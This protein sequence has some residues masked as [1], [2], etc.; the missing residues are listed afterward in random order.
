MNV[1][2]ELKLELVRTIAEIARQ[3]P[4]GILAALVSALESGG[5][6]KSIAHFASTSA[7]REKLRRLEMLCGSQPGI[8]PESL[9]LALRAAAEAASVVGELNR[10]EIAWTGPATDAVSMRRVDQLIYEM[11]SGAEQEIFLVTYA[12]Y[13][14]EKAVKSLSDAVARGVQVS[15][16]IEVSKESGGTLK[17]DGL[18]AFRTAV[19][20]AQLYYWPQSKRKKSDSGAYG[21]MH[22]KCLVMDRKRALVSSANLTDY[23]LEAN[24]ELGLCVER[25]VAKRL[26][27]HFEQLIFRGDLVAVP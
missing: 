20:G 4:P 23:A 16:I 3:L 11:M 8:A 15:L 12:A 19:P 6:E 7:M 22:A 18:E 13:K 5:G 9:A 1:L 26:A 2:T 25:A 24:M 17:F 27:D 21:S 10:T 14:A